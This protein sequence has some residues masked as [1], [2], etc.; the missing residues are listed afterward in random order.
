MVNRPLSNLGT[1]LDN[2][3]V[4]ALKTREHKTRMV[5]D[6]VPVEPL[7]TSKFPPTQ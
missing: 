6:A 3:G 5:A 2:F 1:R 4:K 7:S